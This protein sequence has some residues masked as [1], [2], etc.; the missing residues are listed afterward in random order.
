M[1]W[2]PG[3]NAPFWFVVAVAFVARLVWIAYAH[4]EVNLVDDAGYYDFFAQSIAHGHGYVRPEGT[5][6][7]FWP[8]GYP[9]T[10]AA[11]YAVFGHSF[12]AAK[13]LNVVLGAAT[14]GLVYLLARRWFGVTQSVGAA[15]VYACWP[16]AIGFTTLTM[17][18]PLFTL[19][20]VASM[21]LAAVA[22]QSDSHDL[23]WAAAFG[24]V[25]AA[26]AY[27]RGQALALPFFAAAWL[28]VAG[29]RWDRVVAYLGVSFAVVMALS[30]PWLVR[31]SIV[32]GEPTFL[33][34]NT[35]INLWLGHNPQATGGFDFQQQLGFAGL[36]ADRPLD[37]QEL[38]WNREGFR[39]GVRYMLGHPVDEVRLSV[40]KVLHLYKDDSDAIRWNEENGGAPIFQDS[41]R[42]ELRLLFDGY[43][44]VVLALAIL[45]FAIGIVR[46]QRWTGP[47]A[48]ALVLWTLVHVLFFGEPRL[49]IPV[50]PFLAIVALVP[51]VELWRVLGASGQGETE[52]LEPVEVGSTVP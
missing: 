5:P 52:A 1:K 18:E 38:A 36:F 51:L 21:Y 50:L 33:S 12:L 29:W 25:A 27:V 42:R 17:S 40:Q 6:T 39:E 19:L 8:V 15:F 45:G 31:N 47:I 7:A 16:G 10:L 23:L 9:A 30:L 22:S 26:A 35:G 11:V 32:F 2:R 44:Y 37:Q 20:F 34:T 43:F 41:E 24:V 3:A 28:L 4:P 14:T 46:R 13:L 48:S 49:H